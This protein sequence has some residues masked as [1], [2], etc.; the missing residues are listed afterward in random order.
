[1]NCAKPIIRMGPQFNLTPLDHKNGNLSLSANRSVSKEQ[2]CTSM[3]S[4]YLALVDAAL[5]LGTYQLN[6]NAPPLPPSNNLTSSEKPFHWSGLSNVDVENVREEAELLWKFATSAPCKEDTKEEDSNNI[7]APISPSLSFEAKRYFRPKPSCFQIDN[8]EIEPKLPCGETSINQCSIGQSYSLTFPCLS[9]NDAPQST[10][11]ASTQES[12]STPVQLF[13]R[14]ITT[15]QNSQTKLSA[16]TIANSIMQS[17]LEAINWRGTVWVKSLSDCLHCE[18]EMKTGYRKGDESETIGKEQVKI[19][20]KQQAKIEGQ[21]QVNYD[22]I[23]QNAKPA[24]KRS[25]NVSIINECIIRS[26]KARVL[27][28]IVHA[29]S[30]V[31][32]HDVRTTFQV[33]EQQLDRTSTRKDDDIKTTRNSV[34]R[35]NYGKPPPKKRKTS[36]SNEKYYKLSHAI[37]METRCTVSTKC[38]H[39][40]VG[41][42]HMTVILQAPGVINGTFHRTSDGDIKLVD[43]TVELNTEELASSMEKNS[44]LVIRTAA[45]NYILNPPEPV[46][47][48]SLKMPYSHG[49]IS[50]AISETNEPEYTEEENYETYH[51]HH[52]DTYTDTPMTPYSANQYMSYPEATMIT[53]MKHISRSSSESE[54]MPPPAPRLPLEDGHAIVG[55]KFG[56]TLTPRRVSPSLVLSSPHSDSAANEL[57]DP[58]AS[59]IPSK[60]AANLTLGSMEQNPDVTSQSIAYAFLISPRTPSD[61]GEVSQRFLCPFVAPSL[62]ALVEVACAAHAHCI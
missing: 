51:S 35:V 62:P 15:E 53:P 55:K 22:C 4:E 61:E 25:S 34:G 50:D 32:V 7:R 28:A 8:E 5:K 23:F 31:I 17:F 33:L 20:G 10:T 1:M 56:Y 6:R 27:Q 44:R 54:D 49:I 45:H 46:Q 43:V 37:N 21:Q 38:K 12:T 57:L 58:F 19:E 18:Y 2:Q 11:C 13:S 16:E 48:K 59:P 3:E 30:S 39:S 47:H 60:P 9:L 36:R 42:R 41:L 26:N 24:E 29:T 40:A 52:N 14:P